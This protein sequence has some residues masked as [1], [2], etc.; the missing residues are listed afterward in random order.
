MAPH[1]HWCL[2]MNP[3]WS[4]LSD[5]HAFSCNLMSFMGMWKRKVVISNLPVNLH[6]S[7]Q[8]KKL[9][10]RKATFLSI[11]ITLATAFFEYLV[12]ALILALIS[13]LK[14]SCHLVHRI[15][16]WCCS[17]LCCFAI[18]VQ[19]HREIIYPSDSY[20]LTNYQ[21]VTVRANFTTSELW[22]HR[23]SA[24]FIVIHCKLMFAFLNRFSSYLPFSPLSSNLFLAS[25]ALILPPWFVE[26]GTHP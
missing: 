1:A 6:E 22:P 13:S 24:E 17:R 15:I 2:T 10:W 8:D 14:L 23:M 21:S 9:F 26:A 4:L 11:Y 3:K 16:L 20:K 18:S 7:C 5:T 12:F 25:F 19:N